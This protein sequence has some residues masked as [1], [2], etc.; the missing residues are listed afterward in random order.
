MP[1][2][3]LVLGVLLAGC[4]GER[5]VD[6]GVK[7]GR[8]APCPETPNCVSSQSTDK[9]HVIEPLTYSSSTSEA[10]TDLKKI[11][12][13]MPRTKIVIESD[14]YLSVECTSAIWRFVDDVEFLFDDATKTIHVRSASR[15]GKN[16]LGVNRKR[17]E[18][19]R[20]AWN[21]R[22]MSHGGK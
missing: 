21:A 10:L 14:H 9:D 2:A 3:G 19:I 18:M 6:L 16:D 7:N 8:L 17:V 12:L 15:M 22:K 20:S 1:F 13:Q 5:P 4:S 11:I